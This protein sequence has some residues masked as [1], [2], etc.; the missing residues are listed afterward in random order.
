MVSFGNL[1][2]RK[3]KN[4]TPGVK[5]IHLGLGALVFRINFQADRF[6][7]A[8]FE[9]HGG[10]GLVVFLTDSLKCIGK[11]SRKAEMDSFATCQ[12]YTALSKSVCWWLLT[13]LLLPHYFGQVNENHLSVS[14]SVMTVPNSV[15]GEISITSDMQMTPP[16]WQ[17]VKRN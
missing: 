1:G 11:E 5:P 13:L 17:K 6:P 12:S 16:L 15:L 10:D 9:S 14:S 4:V 7:S 2:S 3:S 8:Y